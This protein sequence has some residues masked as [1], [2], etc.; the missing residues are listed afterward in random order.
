MSGS[1]Q[2][3]PLP[4]YEELNKCK[5]AKITYE[6]IRLGSTPRLAFPAI[7]GGFAVSLIGT[8]SLITAIS[9]FHIPGLE[10]IT[11]HM[12]VSIVLSLILMRAGIHLQS[13]GVDMSRKRARWRQEG[14][15]DLMVAWLKGPTPKTLE[16]AAGFKYSLTADTLPLL[17]K[18]GIYGKETGD[19]AIEEILKAL[20]ELSKPNNVSQLPSNAPEEFNPED[21]EPKAI[22]PGLWDRFFNTFYD[23]VYGMQKA[24]GVFDLILGQVM[25]AAAICAVVFMCSPAGHIPPGLSILARDPYLSISFTFLLLSNWIDCTKRGLRM[26]TLDKRDKNRADIERDLQ[27]IVLGKKIKESSLDEGKKTQILEALKKHLEE[28]PRKVTFYD[29]IHDVGKKIM[30]KLGTPS[31][32][33]GIIITLI[34]AAYLGMSVTNTVPIKLDFLTQNTPLSTLFSVGLISTGLFAIY[35]GVGLNDTTQ[36]KKWKKLSKRCREHTLNKL[37]NLKRPDL[38]SV[39]IEV[40]KPDYTCSIRSA[41]YLGAPTLILGAFCCFCSMVGLIA[42]CGA[43]I[44]PGLNFIIE[45]PSY[46]AFFCATLFAVSLDTLMNGYRMLTYHKRKEKD[47]NDL[48]AIVTEYEKIVNS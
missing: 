37:F 29:K 4:R 21:F 25:F 26:L 12:P 15:S 19:I 30:P 46:S 32:L 34:G 48:Q 38:K 9:G 43:H 3:T 23:K 40:E 8:F 45:D 27:L 18:N 39:D 2:L 33:L 17:P 14:R 13:G 6:W 22:Q 44:N 10:F 41:T 1:I 7:I 20:P 28:E 35:R 11:E 47:F 31:I 5:K 42:A 36:K 24:L 16:D